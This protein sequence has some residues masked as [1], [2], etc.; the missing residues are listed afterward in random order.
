MILII[1]MIIPVYADSNST[2]STNYIE[3]KWWEIIRDN[4][5]LPHIETLKNIEA[6]KLKME[7]E[8]LRLIDLANNKKNRKA[9]KVEIRKLEIKKKKRRK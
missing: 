3:L 4:I 8:N 1:G 2:N 6:E 9:I 5:K 7:L